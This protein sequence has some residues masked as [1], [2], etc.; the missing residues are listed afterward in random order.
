MP[1]RCHGNLLREAHIAVTDLAGTRETH[2]LPGVLARLCDPACETVAFCALQAHQAHAWHAF[3]VQLAAMVCH[4]AGRGIGDPCCR[5]AAWWTDRLIEMAGCEEA[6]CLAVE[7][8]TKPAFLQP[9]TDGMDEYTTIYASPRELDI[10]VTT[11]NHDVKASTGGE[12]HWLFA[13]VTLQTQQGYSGSKNYGIFRMNGGYGNRFATGFADPAGLGRW[14]RRDVAVVMAARTETVALGGFA[15]QDGLALLWLL[16]WDGKKTS[17]LAHKNIDPWC[18]E[19]CRRLR[20]TDDKDYRV[21]RQASSDAS[22]TYI[23]EAKKKW[24]IQN[25]YGDPW[26]ARDRGNKALTPS[27]QGFTASKVVDYLLSNEILPP[28]TQTTVSEDA[29]TD[30]HWYG[31]ALVRGQCKT[32]GWHERAIPIPA[33]ARRLWREAPAEREKLA[34]RA[35]DQIADYDSLRGEV[36]RSALLA[37][38]PAGGRD[39]DGW[40]ACFSCAADAAFFP[41]LW[42]HLGETPDRARRLWR[43]RIVELARETLRDAQAALPDGVRRWRALAGSRR[44]FENGLSSKPDKSGSFRASIEQEWPVTLTSSMP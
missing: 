39:A 32:N 30:L 43:R 44:I 13:L 25:G 33:A 9:P 37:L 16:P 24:V 38:L 10:L 2:T 27:E 41:D 4:R 18:L 15:A 6:W 17:A 20:L 36:L 1:E 3:L 29:D 34:F 7:D 28:P 8:L 40:L 21:A 19:I 5:D 26:M 35:K 22:R 31:R 42:A 23:A 11:R 12:E 14:M